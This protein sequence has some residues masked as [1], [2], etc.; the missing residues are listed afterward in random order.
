MLEINAELLEQGQS[1]IMFLNK[2]MPMKMH[3]I[4]EIGVAYFSGCNIS[5]CHHRLCVYPMCMSSCR[6]NGNMKH[7]ISAGEISTLRWCRIIEGE[8][9]QYHVCCCPGS[10]RCQVT[11]SHDIDCVIYTNPCLPWT[12]ISTTVKPVYNDHQMGYFS[13]F[14]SSSRWP[15][16]T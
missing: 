7:N 5:V 1:W 11:S 14:W 16:A 4:A 10:L 13:A 9:W 2:M 15:R 12:M 8:L 3:G 6:L